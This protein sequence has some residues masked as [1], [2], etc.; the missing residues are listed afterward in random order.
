MQ[1]EKEQQLE[2]SDLHMPQD[3]DTH[4][5]R[6]RLSKKGSM[7]VVDKLPANIHT[8]RENIKGFFQTYSGA[9]KP[10]PNISE[11]PP[12]PPPSDPPTAEIEHSE[13][14]VSTGAVEHEP[15]GSEIER[16]EATAATCVAEHGPDHGP[17]PAQTR[18]AQVPTGSE[19][20]G[21]EAT[22]STGAKEQEPA[23]A[24]I[25]VGQ[26]S[27]EDEPAGHNTAS[28]P[29]QDQ[30]TIK[31]EGTA[32]EVETI[33][34]VDGDPDQ[35]GVPASMS[36]KPQ[37]QPRGDVGS[38]GEQRATTSPSSRPEPKDENR[39]STAE[40]DQHGKEG[41]SSTSTLPQNE[42]DHTQEPPGELGKAS[43]DDNAEDSPEEYK[44]LQGL[45]ER[46]RAF[47]PEP[48]DDG[49]DDQSGSDNEGSEEMEENHSENTPDKGTSIDESNTVS[50]TAS[51]DLL[52]ACG[53]KSCGDS[54]GCNGGQQGELQ[55]PDVP[56][57]ADS[58]PMQQEPEEDITVL[59]LPGMECERIVSQL[60]ASQ[61]IVMFWT[62]KKLLGMVYLA[63]GNSSEIVGNAEVQH[64]KRISNLAE[65]RTLTCFQNASLELRNVWKNRILNEQKPL[66][67]WTIIGT[68]K[69]ERSLHISGRVA[70]KHFTVDLKRLQSSQAQVA[71]P[72]LDLHETA[73]YFLHRLGHEDLK[74]LEITMK[75]LDQ[76]EVRIGTSCSGTDIA[77]SVAK[78]TI[79]VLAKHFN[80][81][82]IYIYTYTSVSVFVVYG[83]NY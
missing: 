12:M 3:A 8:T 46:I 17:A 64:Q 76:R 48:A 68:Q 79:Q 31:P 54:T 63:K 22:V 71:I 38:M 44:R 33:Q 2:V 15:T 52:S 53:E 70:G 23:P 82:C 5:R 77:V 1:P 83:L 59:R 57:P 55:H 26:V 65:L 42:S 78:A 51:F 50:K 28:V 58:V 18:A 9:L 21:S 27:V 30:E 49:S 80:A 19:I 6:A 72:G 16:S 24:P 43:Q 20:E 35:T 37:D 7:V 39:E 40:A 11:Q 60:C 56:G 4:I 14:T 66:Y 13:A 25:P 73:W 36:P 69:L 81:T 75:Q 45:V 41:C 67:V 34:E 32:M 74:K 47:K 62:N 61:E 10:L 29:T